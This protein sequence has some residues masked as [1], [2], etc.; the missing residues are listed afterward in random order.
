MPKS[1]ARCKVACA[2]QKTPR[3]RSGVIMLLSH[4]PSYPDNDAIYPLVIP[5]AKRKNKKKQIE[6]KYI[7]LL[8]PRAKPSVFKPRNCRVNRPIHTPAT[9]AI[10]SLTPPP[11]VLGIQSLD[12][13]AEKESTRPHYSFI[14]AF[15]PSRTP[16]NKKHAGKKTK[17]ERDS[18][19]GCKTFQLSLFIF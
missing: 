9:L 12:A 4:H 2:P 3:N 14:C 19:Q 18:P 7:L 1:S 6:R 10:A 5:G 8:T 17:T 15:A 16:S 13:R 11:S